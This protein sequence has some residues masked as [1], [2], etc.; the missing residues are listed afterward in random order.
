MRSNLILFVLVLVLVLENPKFV[1]RLLDTH[2]RTRRR[3]T[4][5]AVAGTLLLKKLRRLI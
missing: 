3:M 1:R 4:T 2:S 5:K